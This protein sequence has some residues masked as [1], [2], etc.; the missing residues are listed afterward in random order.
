MPGVH[1]IV[2]IAMMAK[3]SVSNQ[4]DTS[5]LQSQQS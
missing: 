4:L 5:L 3:K 2:M 1:L